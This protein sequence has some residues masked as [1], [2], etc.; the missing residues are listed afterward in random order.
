M[1]FRCRHKN[2]IDL[3]GYSPSPPILVYEF[4]EQGN[5]FDRLHKVYMLLYGT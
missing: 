4:M 5:L 3:M 2:L 1:N